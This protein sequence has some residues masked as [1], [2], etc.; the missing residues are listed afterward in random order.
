MIH[1]DT[2]YLI[3]AMFPGTPQ[4]A[5]LRAWLAAGEPVN[6]SAV[7][8]AEFF[9]GPLTAEQSRLATALFPAPEPLFAADAVRAAELFNQPGRRRGSLAD[10]MIATVAIRAGA[11]LATENLGDFRPFVPFGLQLFTPP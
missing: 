6:V 7:A 8:W 10:C 1:L 2:N 3:P 11:T 5:R 4:D 9:C